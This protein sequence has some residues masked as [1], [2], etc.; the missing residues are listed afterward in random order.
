MTDK[1]NQP[2]NQ[3]SQA[4]DYGEPWHE[5]VWLNLKEP[6]KDVRGKEIAAR[7][8]EQVAILHHARE[9]LFLHRIIACVNACAG[10]GNEELKNPLI[11]VGVLR[12][13]L[14]ALGREQTAR[15]K[16][17]FEEEFEH[18]L[19]V[20]PGFCSI[21]IDAK[22]MSKHVKAGA[23]YKIVEALA[24][25][26]DRGCHFSELGEEAHHLINEIYWMDRKKR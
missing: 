15:E 9:R 8:G 6:S 7:D 2:T 26:W 24:K 20:E 1:L 13:A 16:P 18:E 17:G 3:H 23:L 5:V 10:L 22:D 4:P 25:E 14:Q 11:S 19:P 21:S 12:N